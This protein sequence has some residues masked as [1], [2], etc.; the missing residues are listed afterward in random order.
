MTVGTDEQ[1]QFNPSSKWQ[2]ELYMTLCHNVE[3]NHQLKR[4]NLALSPFTKDDTYH[5]SSW[6]NRCNTYLSNT[7]PPCVNEVWLPHPVTNDNV[8][9]ITLFYHF[10]YKRVIAIN[11][12][13][14]WTL[15]VCRFV[16]WHHRVKKKLICYVHWSQKKRLVLW[17]SS[18]NYNSTVVKL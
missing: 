17:R 18:R 3:N 2:V 1:N 16:Y 12:N 6:Q 4:R 13:L 7:A 15:V 9:L 5:A 10:V 11:V 8:A 14:C